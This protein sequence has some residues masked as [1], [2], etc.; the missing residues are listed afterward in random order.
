MKPRLLLIVIAMAA[1]TFA[2]AS[3]VAPTGNASPVLV[4]LFTSEGCSSCPPADALLQNLDRSQ[5][6]PGAQIIVLSEHVDYWNHEGWRDPYSSSFFSE[7]QESY[8]HRFGL[9]SSFTPQMVVDGVNQLNGSDAALAEHAIESARSHPKIAIR[10]SGFSVKDPGTLHIHLEVDALP[11]SWQARKANVYVVV[12]LDHA[13]SQVLAGENKGHLITHVAVVQSIDKVGVVE[14]GKA[15]ERDVSVK[16]KPL[17]D[18]SNV[19]L[20]AFVQESDD[21]PVLGASSLDVA[22]Q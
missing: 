13:A 3:I 12:A 5:P 20:I 16:H 4:E 19:R 2:V 15:F 18:P 22:K 21:G 11:Q 10:A 17:A 6:I 9:N 8:E 7:R 14:R 1:F